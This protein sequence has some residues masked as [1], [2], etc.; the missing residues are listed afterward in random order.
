V[1]KAVAALVL[2]EIA[3]LLALQDAEPYRVR[4]YRTAARAVDTIEGD[5]ERRVRDGELATVPGLGPA[6]IGVL[7]ELVETGRSR[8][9]DRLRAETPAGMVRLRA[10]S[11]LG[12]KRVRTLH[13]ELGIETLEQLREAAESGRIADLKGFGPATQKRVL[14]GIDFVDESTGRRRQPQA[15]ATAHRLI[16]HLE[17]LEVQAVRLAGE[18]RRGC[19]TVDGIE[20]LA[21]T[22]VPDTAL[23]AFV[24]LP[25]LTIAER[26]EGGRAHAAMADGAAVRLRCVT[27]DQ[28]AAAWVAA[29]G[30]DAHLAQLRARAAS[31]GLRLDDSG[32]WDD[33]PAAGHPIDLADEAALYAALELEWVPPELREGRGEVE[34]AAEGRLPTLVHYD[35]LRGTFH[36]HT[37]WSDGRATV[38]EMAEGALARGWRYLGIADHSVTASYAGGLTIDEVRHQQ[39]EIDRWN[40]EP[41]GELWLFK[42]VEADILSDGS[43][44]YPDDVLASFDYVVG[45]VHSAFRMKEAAMTR[46]ITRA[47]SNPR[48][49][50]LGHPTGR[51]LLTRE[52]YAV[53]MD[54]VI[55]AAAAAGAAIEINGDPHRMDMDWRHWPAAKGKGRPAAPSTPTPTPWRGSAPSSTACPWP[56]RAGSSRRT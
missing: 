19:E 37:S 40:A 11:G 14:E 47:V 46:R 32:L 31:L 28:A 42:G 17:T 2:E 52:P 4:A 50:I 21:V 18:L 43:L 54:A 30:S 5:L 13:E 38:A 24:L 53:D 41:G 20:L 48:L 55:D 22:D 35:D 34:W 9:Y 3:A 25:A 33:D 16:D 49:T 8:L 12:P 10:V 27:P 36:C 29:T 7:R 56:G 23:D 6:T 39:R 45:S 15:Y 1:D 44:D 26:L 51:L